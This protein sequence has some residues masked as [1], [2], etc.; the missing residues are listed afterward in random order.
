M[1]E[2]EKRRP[3][4]P[5]AADPRQTIGLRVT[6]AERAELVAAAEAAGMGLSV[7]VREKALAAARKRR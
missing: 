5:N 7:Y 2:A 4:R 3:G 1:T 6:S